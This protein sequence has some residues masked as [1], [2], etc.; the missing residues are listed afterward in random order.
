[1]ALA[2]TVERAVDAG[3]AATASL[4]PDAVPPRRRRA[5]GPADGARAPRPASQP[6]PPAPPAPPPP[7]TSRARRKWPF[8][9]GIAALL[10][11]VAVALVLL[12]GD[13]EKPADTP[14]IADA[15]PPERPLN[16]AAAPPLEVGAGADGVA[17]GAGSDWVANKER[18][19]LTRMDRTGR[20]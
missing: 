1:M 8:V 20:P 15:A 14:V 5:G 6:S 19:T 7:A 3:T 11:A 4:G 18:N 10:G 17:V 2:L 16:P 13:D 9:V 12:Q